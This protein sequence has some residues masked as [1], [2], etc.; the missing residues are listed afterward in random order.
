MYRW[1]VIPV[2]TLALV[3]CDDT[4][5]TV[6]AP[7]P[8]EPTREAITYFGRMILVD[9]DG[10]RGQIHLEDGEV[11]WFPAVRD[12]KAFTL[13][14]EERKDIAAMYVS[15]MATAASWNDPD[16]WMPARDAFYVI[17]SDARGG[18]GM[19]EAVPFSDRTAADTFASERGGRVTMWDDIPA[20]YILSASDDGMNM[21]MTH[22]EGQHQ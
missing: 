2:L 5:S 8:V 12:V 14:P 7:P 13:L 16:T 6:E 21:Q 19:P 1:I 15:D 22:G 11:L 20:D 10:P 18:M 3:A 9:H 4:S 17:E